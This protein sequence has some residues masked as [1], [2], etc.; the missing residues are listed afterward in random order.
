MKERKTGMKKLLSGLLSLM[1]LI[2]L[3]PNSAFGTENYVFGAKES[4]N[5]QT[6]NFS[7]AIDKTDVVPG[8]VVHITAT[9]S[10]NCI[11]RVRPHIQVENGSNIRGLN[12]IKTSENT[13]E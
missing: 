4:E 6:C 9:A 8:D 5:K 3:V 1:M 11:D 7:F 13:Y 12:Y 10:G 2:M